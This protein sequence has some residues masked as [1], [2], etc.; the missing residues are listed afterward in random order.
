MTL[1]MAGT[2][3]VFRKHPETPAALPAA[4]SSIILLPFALSFSDPMQVSPNEIMF[5]T[6]FGLVFAAASIT[7]FEGSRR[8]PSAETALL[9]ILE[10]PLAPILALLILSEAPTSHTLIGG[11]IILGAVLWSQTGSTRTNGA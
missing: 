3:V 6:L 10:M 1:M 8:L 5:L 11:L 9:S 4:L 2:M 7:L